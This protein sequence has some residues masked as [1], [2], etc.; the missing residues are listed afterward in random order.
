MKK[1]VGILTYWGV[2][3]YGAWAQA[4]TLNNA[5]KQIVGN[6]AEVVHINYLCDYHWDYYYKNNERLYNSFS[7][8]WN[9]IP[10]TEKLEAASLE[11]TFFDIIITGSDAIWEFSVPEMGNDCHLI[12]NDLNTDKL[13]SYAASFGVTSES[14][15]LEPWVITGLKKYDNVMVR[16]VHS[17]DVINRLNLDIKAD[18][19]VD[20]VLLWN[21]KNDEKIKLPKYEKY[22]V[23]Y[24]IDFSDEFKQNVQKLAGEKGC[25]LISVGFV[26]DWCDMSLKM[27]ELRGPEWIGMFKNAECVI[28]STFHGLMVGLSFEKNIKFYQAEYVKNRSQTLKEKLNIPDHTQDFE[29]DI[30]YSYTT[31]VLNK[32]REDSLNLLKKSL[33]EL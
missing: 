33:G 6:K 7:Y 1:K 5:L 15:E 13:V 11:K 9:E 16:D 32:M 20:P 3:N 25:K 22:F 2:P 19:V 8:S 14:S 4:Y 29:K 23:V 18:I 17:K 12:G 26:N 10:H 30:D 27:I 21:F 28:T 24:G 31:P